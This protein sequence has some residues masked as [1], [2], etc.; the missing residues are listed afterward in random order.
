MSTD[1]YLSR[2]NFMTFEKETL[3][4][5]SNPNKD[6]MCQL[7]DIKNAFIILFQLLVMLNS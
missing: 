3:D 4:Y 6:T 7:H 2:Y 1:E 5:E